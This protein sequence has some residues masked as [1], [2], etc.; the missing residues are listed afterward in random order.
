M[1][2]G[3]GLGC[4]PS[5]APLL[6]CCQRCHAVAALEALAC[7]GATLLPRR[8]PTS[9]LP[10]RRGAVV[11]VG[12]AVDLALLTVADDS[13]WVEPTP[14]LPLA[15]GDVPALQENVLVR[16]CRA[17][18][19]YAWACTHVLY[20]C[21]PLSGRNVLVAS[22]FDRM[23]A[24]RSRGSIAV[25]DPQSPSCPIV[26]PLALSRCPAPSRANAQV[27]GYP[28]GGDNTSVTSGVVSRV[29]VTQYVHAASH[30]MAI[31]IDAAINPGNR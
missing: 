5:A 26:L 31:Q 8:V 10:P 19:C 2:I 18:A 28:T 23:G 12:H 9:A 21:V 17:R 29:E 25:G 1:S 6:A 3:L 13:F 24:H 4:T 30:L 11:A 16:P 20:S 14:M 22:T 7:T 15:L 27:I